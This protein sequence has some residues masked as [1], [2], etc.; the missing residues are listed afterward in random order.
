[1]VQRVFK[2]MHN[3]LMADNLDG[4]VHCACREVLRGFYPYPSART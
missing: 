2:R 3:L 1:M 4:A